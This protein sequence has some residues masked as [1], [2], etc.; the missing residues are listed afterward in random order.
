MSEIQAVSIRHEAI[1]DHLMAHPCVKLGDVA[2]KFGVTAGWLSQI[3]H[4]DAFQALLKEK[5]GVAF[6]HTVLPLREKMVAVANIALDR[7]MDQV[8]F[9]TETKAMKDVADSMLEK[10]GFGSKQGGT[11]INDNSTHVTVLRAEVE[12]ARKLLGKAERP[13]PGV[14][15]D[16]ER[17]PIAISSKGEP[18]MGEVLKA[19]SPVH[20]SESQ[21][22]WSEAETGT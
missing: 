22:E 14:I 17:A 15:I 1:M 9:E 10:L 21:G 5:Q 12:E 18:I 3:I 6:H 19:S 4:S 11:V 2:I 20:S 16:G 7:L 8:P 13:Q